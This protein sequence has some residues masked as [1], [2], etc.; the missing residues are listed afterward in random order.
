[1]PAWATQTRPI[2]S[3]AL[4]ASRNVLL[5]LR[6][7][8][9][10][11][12]WTNCFR[13]WS[14]QYP[15]ECCGRE[16]A[17]WTRIED[18]LS[19]GLAGN[20]LFP[21]LGYDVLRSMLRAEPMADPSVDGEI[22]SS[23]FRTRARTVDHLGREQIADCPTAVSELWKNAFD[24]YARSVQLDIFDGASPVAAIVDDGHGMNREEFMERWLVVGTEAK[25]YADDTPE[26]DRNG[27][28][29][30]PRQGQKGIGRLSCAH[31]GTTLLLVS[32]R[33]HDPFVA[34]LVDW[35]LFEN[36]FIDLFDIRIPSTEFDDAEQLMK[37]LPLLKDAL[38][39]NVSG[40]AERD[41]RGK[42]IRDAWQ[43]FDDRFG[44]KMTG[45]RSPSHFSSTELIDSIEN[46]PYQER[47]LDQWKV[48]D[49]NSRHGTA[50]LVAGLSYDLR[51][52]LD[53]GSPDQTARFAKDRFFE[54]LVNFVD[55]FR[56]FPSAR[57]ES[58]DLQ[59]V[60][61]VQVWTGKK[62]REVVGPKTQFHRGQIDGLEHRIEGTV[63]RNGVFGGKVKAF[64]DVQHEACRIQP[65]ADVL[66]PRRTESEL[67]PFKI[68]I[69]TLEFEQ[70]NT[71]H[72]ESE[73][74]YYKDLLSKYS[75]FLIFRDD[76]RVLPYGREDNDFFEIESRRSKHAGREFWNHRQMFGRVA[77]TRQGNPNLKDKAGREGLLDNRAAKT[78]KAL[79]SNIL[80]E[81]ARKYFG[82]DSEIRKKRLPEISSENRRARALKA[83]KELRRRLLREF[84][85]KLRDMAEEMPEFVRTV[86]DYVN[87]ASLDTPE[88]IFRAQR[89]LEEIREELADFEIAEP[90]SKLRPYEE[91]KLSDYRSMLWSV[92][93]R[94]QQL[95]ESIERALE[96]A[97]EPPDPMKFLQRQIDEQEARV[98]IRIQ[99]WQ[100]AIEDLQKSEHRRISSIVRERRQ[101]FRTE[102]TPLLTRFR[103]RGD[104]YLEIS[105]RID[106]LFEDIESK[107][108]ELFVS[109]IAALESLQES[110][111]L[112]HL[113]TFGMEE[114]SELRV[115]LERLNSLAQLGIAVEIL[116]HE[117]QSFDEMIGSGLRGL[118]AD[119]RA[120]DA[121]EEIA[122]GYEGLT[123]QLRFLSPLRLSGPKID[124]WVTGASIAN[125][126][127]DFFKLMLAKNRISLD[128]TEDFQRFRIFDQ[129]S[130]LLPVFINLLNNSIYW[131]GTSDQVNRKIVLDV[132]DRT[133]AEIIV[134][135]N[136]PGVAIEDIDSL[137]TL[138]FT[139]KIQGGRGVGLYLCRA[140][141]V[142]GGH[143]IRYEPSAGSTFLGGANFVI[144]F[145]GAE[146]D[147]E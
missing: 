23:A 73:L 84:R 127:T 48:T 105:R 114:I 102:A 70:K 11:C 53:D 74:Q 87:D 110:I 126:L 29:P 10:R 104:P 47:H 62:H 131:L 121:A 43:A 30:R 130:R 35:R 4:A 103:A 124:E 115:E 128:V 55:P 134:S 67:G 19:L 34:A 139:R 143:T 22:G 83:E 49:G 12:S 46:V 88:Q 24:A 31:L 2:A 133:T 75:G 39:E 18:V 137:F 111:D 113:A 42:R 3:R 144:E 112:E 56:A 86:D 7:L 97:A 59:F 118:P 77:I 85:A 17:C 107:N 51:A 138:F 79:V 100:K 27:L 99:G 1:M 119:V 65:P 41:G 61:S 58:N 44:D 9:G 26:V 96:A 68:Y 15:D 140:N 63:D 25:A 80:K 32:K 76:L 89:K 135:D 40:G 71:T 120:S 141:L 108:R 91:K 72:S 101:V 13:R 132:F 6:K 94:V 33:T 8:A 45:N 14:W 82:T 64:G 117:L 54:T 78:L 142:A 38:V 93:E 81:A 98:S 92:R 106:E 146:F 5:V 28:N 36:P 123:D 60:C 116:G 129:R 95:N 52:Q 37:R 16:F 57:S 109:Y 122:F 125:Y 90:P 136:G 69:A 21:H 66:I 145:R 50:L 20:E 147:G